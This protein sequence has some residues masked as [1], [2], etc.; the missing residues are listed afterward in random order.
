MLDGIDQEI[1]GLLQYDGR[2]PVSSIAEVLGLSEG[3]VRRRLAK[4]TESGKLQVVGIVK[5]R[6]LGWNEACMIGISVQPNL[7][8]QAAEMIAEFPEVVYLFQ[9]SGEF[10]LFAEVYCRN[11]AHFVSFLNNQLQKVPGVERTQSY[12]ILKM[13]KLSYHWGDSQARVEGMLRA[14]DQQQLE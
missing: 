10:D 1:V 14:A 12:F 2:M 5:P 7:I 11:R 9:A 6:E 8:N 4:L 13:Y 3:A